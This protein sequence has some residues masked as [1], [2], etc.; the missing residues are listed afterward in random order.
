MAVLCSEGDK[1]PLYFVKGSLDV[2]LQRS[3]TVFVNPT[4]NRPLTP[5]MR[6]R[7][8]E[9]AESLASEGYRVLAFAEGKDLSNLSIVGLVAMADHPRPGVE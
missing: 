8:Q 7:L 4:L 1:E 2:I 6:T 5:T 3:T 9:V